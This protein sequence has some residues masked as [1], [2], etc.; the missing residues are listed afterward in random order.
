[1]PPRKDGAV[2]AGQNECPGPLASV[3][4]K[5]LLCR[6]AAASKVVYARVKGFPHWPAQVL[7][8]QAAKQHLGN[9]THKSKSDVPVIF[10]GTSEIA[11]VGA[12]DVASWEEGMRNTYHTKGRKNKKFIVALE[13]VRDFL[14]VTGE[15][16]SPHGWWCAPPARNAAPVPDEPPSSD[17]DEDEDQEEA[18]LEQELQRNLS[19]RYAAAAAAAA[20]TAA[21]AAAAE[22]KAHMAHQQQAAAAAAAAGMLRHAGTAAYGGGRHGAYAEEDAYE[23]AAGAA[24]GRGSG[25]RGQLWGRGSSAG[26]SRPGSEHDEQQRQPQQQQQVHQS[27]RKR[28]TT[29]NGAGYCYASAAGEAWSDGEQQQQQQQQQF[30]SGD[31]G[32]EA[33]G[34]YG[35]SSSLLQRRKRQLLQQEH[36]AGGDGSESDM[37]DTEMAAMAIA[38]LAQGGG[39]DQPHALQQQQLEVKHHVQ[40]LPE[41]QQQ[42]LMSLA[43]SAAAAAAALARSAPEPQQELAALPA[44]ADMQQQQQQPADDK[45]VSVKLQ[46][47]AEGVGLG[48]HVK[49]QLD[50]AAAA[51]GLPHAGGHQQQQQQQH[52]RHPHVQRHAGLPPLPG[53]H[54]EQ[55]QQQQQHD[56]PPGKYEHSGQGLPCSSSWQYAVSILPCSAIAVAPA[57]A[58]ADSSN[59]SATAQQQQQ[60]HVVPAVSVC[61]DSAYYRHLFAGFAIS[62]HHD[63]EHELEQHHQELPAAA[64]GGEQHRPAHAA[65]AAAVAPLPSLAEATAAAAAAAVGV[66]SGLDTADRLAAAAAAAAASALPLGPRRARSG[67]PPHTLAALAAIRATFAGPLVLPPAPPQ[68]LQQIALAAA[69]GN[70]SG[71]ASGGNSGSS[72]GSGR[73]T[74]VHWPRKRN[75]GGASVAATAAAAAAAAAAHVLTPPNPR[76]DHLVAALLLENEP[77]LPMVSHGEADLGFQLPREMLLNRPPKFEYLKRNLFVSRERPK[78]MPKD[79]VSV[80]NCRV[81]KVVLPDGS[82]A[83]TGCGD[84]CLNRLSFIHCDPRTCPC[85]QACSNKPFHLLKAPQLDVFLTENRGHGVRMTQPLRRGNFVV[86]YAGEVIDT[87]E[88]QRRMEASRESGEQHFYIME[89]GPGLFIDA[90]RKGNH[91]RLLNSCCDPNCETQKW[92]DAATGEVRI[93]IFSTRDIREDEELTYDYM[94]EH[95]GLAGMAQGFKCQCGAKNCRGTMDVNPERKRDWGRRLEVFWEGDGVFYRGTVTGYSTSS[96]KHTIMYDDGDTERVKLDQVPHR[97]LDGDA[98]P[99]SSAQAASGSPGPGAE[100]RGPRISP[101]PVVQPLPADSGSWSQTEQD[102][103]EEGLGLNMAAQDLQGLSPCSVPGSA[104][105]AAAAGRPGSGRVARPLGLSPLGPR[106]AAAAAAAASFGGLA[107][108]SELDPAAAAAAGVPA[109]AGRATGLKRA[110]AAVAAAEEELEEDEEE[111]EE[112]YEDEEAADALVVLGM[113]AEAELGDAAQQQQQQQQHEPGTFQ[114]PQVKRRRLG[115]PGYSSIEQEAQAA[116]AAAFNGGRGLGAWPHSSSTSSQSACGH[117]GLSAGNGAMDGASPL[118]P[119]GHLQ[120][121]QHLAQLPAGA[122]KHSMLAPGSS[123]PR[124]GAQVAAG[125]LSGSGLGREHNHQH[126]L[127]HDDSMDVDGSGSGADEYLPLEQLMSGIRA[128]KSQG[129]AIFKAGSRSADRQCGA[130]GEQQLRQVQHAGAAAAAEGPAA[131]VLEALK[132]L[133]RGRLGQLL[134]LVGHITPV[135]QQ[136]HDDVADGLLGSVAAG[137]SGSWAGSSN[138]SNT[139]GACQLPLFC[140]SAGSSTHQQQQQLAMQQQ[141]QL[142]PGSALLQPAASTSSSR[143][144]LPQAAHPQLCAQQHAL[145]QQQLQAQQHVPPQQQGP[146]AASLWQQPRPYAQPAAPANRHNAAAAAAAPSVGSSAGS[147]QAQ[148]LPV[149]QQQAAAAHQAAAAA[150]RAGLAGQ[151]QQQR[152]QAVYAVPHSAQISAALALHHHHQQQQQQAAAACARGGVQGSFTGSSA[153]PAP[154]GSAAATAMGTVLLGVPTGMRQQQQQQPYHLALQ[155]PPSQQQQQQHAVPAPPAGGNGAAVVPVRLAVPVGYGTAGSSNAPASLPMQQQ[156]QQQV[157]GSIT[158]AFRAP[159]AAAC[160]SPG[161]AAAAAAQQCAVLLA[162]AGSGGSPV[163]AG[164]AALVAGSSAAA[165]AAASAAAGASA[166]GSMAHMLQAQQQPVD[167][168]AQ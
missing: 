99:R 118:S 23:N 167:V 40:L 137:R 84:N 150:A 59:G 128:I 98:S 19:S 149:L 17:D 27:R 116:A 38:Q 61:S 135:L 18:L 45:P 162:A 58:A 168:V 49:Q 9:V 147:W 121:P 160:G 42:Q 110:A 159:S 51:D 95:Y 41:Q 65:A 26:R 5:P 68:A 109:A 94:F 124:S 156:Q 93:G 145:L 163:S 152:S 74:S 8:K 111:E 114:R 30:R 7:S 77:Q 154:A 108:G 75:N 81:E 79:D 48:V 10:F 60:R 56:H 96:G 37:T 115:V 89:M 90:R 54:T 117:L 127:P 155:Q 141:L 101:L 148:V 113:A 104:A 34:R 142:R 64:A 136:K 12:K 83:L 126:A 133:K 97:W 91:A 62:D 164:S 31:T 72:A 33:N 71:G 112:M 165:A 46:S 102:A 106:S 144:Q 29:S 2:A 132:P 6:D 88:L 166:A 130:A 76:L 86:E 100:R 14:S 153:V 15:R 1:M 125:R 67:A 85:G 139:V 80:C 25:R 138:S 28:H 69:V 4:A 103:A 24:A 55:Q 43:G 107:A 87:A 3:L 13:Q 123:R 36:G 39:W 131:V 57:A 151:Q 11:W 70:S 53:S 143:T 158:G 50:G 35:S 129:P 157:Q 119:A 20:A 44:A 63:A 22:A 161:G 78:R 73:G 52:S 105:A 120:G 66:Q 134:N 16:V 82:E 140:G 122:A 92:R 32:A 21:A 146:P 47:G